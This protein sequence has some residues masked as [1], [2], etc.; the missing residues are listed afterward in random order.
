VHCRLQIVDRR[1]WPLLLVALLTG[2][3]AS[4]TSSAPPSATTAPPVQLA[5]ATATT[6]PTSAPPTAA[7]SATPQTPVAATPTSLPATTATTSATE[8][9]T[10]APTTPTS[11][12]ATQ[13]TRDGQIILLDN[14][15]ATIRTVRPDGSDPQVLIVVAKQPHE[16]VIRMAAAPNGRYLVY[17]LA[18][19][20]GAE[21]LRSF[22]VAGGVASQIET[23]AGTPRFSPDATRFVAAALTAD[24][25]YGGP[26]LLYD[27]ATRAATRLPVAGSAE[28]FADGTRLLYLDDTTI[29]IYDT[30]S[31]TTT[32]VLS[33][34]NAGDERW[35]IEQAHLL[36]DEARVLF[37]GG[38]QNLLGASGNGMR[39]WTVPLGGGAPEPAS[40]PSGNRVP[41][42]SPN[43]Q[44]DLLAYSES[45]HVNVCISAY[46]LAVRP[47]TLDGEVLYAPLPDTDMDT[48]FAY[49][50]GFAW[51]DND[52]IV[53]GLRP[54]RCADTTDFQVGAASI[55]RWN[56]RAG[57]AAPIKIADGSYPIWIR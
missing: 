19:Y 30:S 14:D 18:D 5:T 34:P 27:L 22:L 47:S 51:V 38:Q 48:R 35:Y 43:P 13:T 9:A 28:W 41:E 11:E 32:S 3:G 10:T 7:T 2:C 39:W 40:E 55:Y 31:G 49:I 44:L 12:P 23:L 6:P 45:F 56:V 52:H 29:G 24:G 20:N 36:P 4:G 50:E 37:Y 26:L 25:A 46:S 15:G 16:E 53:Y 57:D 54:Y 42:F 1:L 8:A 33:L 21:P 17:S